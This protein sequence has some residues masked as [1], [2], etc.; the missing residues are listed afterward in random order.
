MTETSERIPTAFDDRTDEYHHYS[1]EM[2]ISGAPKMP[3][4][5]KRGVLYVPEGARAKW[6]HGSDI[7][8]IEVRGAV[9]TEDGRRGDD[10]TVKYF[11]PAI[12]LSRVSNPDISAPAWLLALFGIEAPTDP[13]P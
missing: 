8:W 7:E 4:P 3:F 13:Q 2:N 12:P 1:R 5:E 11:T 10:V 6:V 9:R